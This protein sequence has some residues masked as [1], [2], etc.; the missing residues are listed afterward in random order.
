M[1]KKKKSDDF[2]DEDRWNRFWDID[3]FFDFDVDEYFEKMRRYLDRLFHTALRGEAEIRGPF[4]YGFT[5]RIGPDGKPHIQEFGNTKPYLMGRK[6]EGLGREPITDITESEG[7]VYVTAE[8]PG[9]E[10]KDIDIR[11]TEDTLTIDVKNPKRR[12]YKS[13]TLPCAVDPDSA[14]ATY[15]NGI[16][17]I[18]IKKKAVEERKGKRIKIE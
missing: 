7:E 15:K 11:L 14:K 8:I 17:D 4:I 2:W 5:M 12:Y 3:E 16:L 9:V 18:T 13:I 10:K 1:K 6:G